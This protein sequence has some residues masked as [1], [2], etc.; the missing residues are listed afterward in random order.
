MVAAHAP[1][2]LILASRTQA[3]LDAVADGIRATNT[4]DVRSVV[5]DLCSLASVRSAAAAILGMTPAIDVL[6]NN[7]GILMR[8]TYETSVDGY[9]LAF[10]TNH[11]G[12]FLLTNL[13]MPALLNHPDGS[14]ARVVNISS[15]VHSH[16]PF[17][18]T[19][20]WN[21]NLGKDYSA[22]QSYG[23]SKTAN[24][25]FSLSLARKLGNKGIVSLGVD[26]GSK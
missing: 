3:N 26:P 10:A 21:F 6:F 5:V 14:G 16:T 17:L 22:I 9:E 2:L 20:G 13:L 18:G 23:Q 7:A 24:L 15:A 19:A 11:L 12:H 1:R 4:V 8:P 25:L